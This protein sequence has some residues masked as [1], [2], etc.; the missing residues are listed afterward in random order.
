[1]NTTR[2][3]VTILVADDD[4]GHAILIQECLED[5][6]VDNPII[7]FADGEEIW[8]FLSTESDNP[9][10]SP[11]NKYL[12]L[13]DIRMPKMDGVDVLRRIK[14][15]EHIANIPVIMLTTTDNP[16][17]IKECYDLGCNSYITKP[18]DIIEFEEVVKNLGVFIKSIQI[19]SPEAIKAP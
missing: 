4:D 3:E 14:S 5:S 15:T 8:N 6:G 11:E 18:I 7:R 2:D 17:E 10:F 1:M 13:L 9:K 19:S 12:I 16:R